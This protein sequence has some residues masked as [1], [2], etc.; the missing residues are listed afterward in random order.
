MLCR[1]GKELKKGKMSITQSRYWSEC[2][3][4]SLVMSFSSD[5]DVLILI[6]N[7]RGHWNNFT[8]IKC[9]NDVTIT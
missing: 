8:I 7:H 6:T 2:V 1:I 5:L 4:L 9:L 3:V